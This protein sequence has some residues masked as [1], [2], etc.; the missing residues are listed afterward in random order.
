MQL[1]PLSSLSI[2]STNNS[3][4]IKDPVANQ[5]PEEKKVPEP[6]PEP[7]NC[8]KEIC[9]K[10]KVSNPYHST[11]ILSKIKNINFLAKYQTCIDIKSKNPCY[12]I[13]MACGLYLLLA[14]MNKR[15]NYQILDKIQN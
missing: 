15:T 9:S 5:S 14:F 7:I 10:I 4:E 6:L 3:E 11:E 1:N 12:G 8:D 2:S 13:Y